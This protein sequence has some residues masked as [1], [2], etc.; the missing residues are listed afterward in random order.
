M[1]GP[2]VDRCD[3]DGMDVQFETCPLKSAWCDAGLAD[4]EVTQLCEIAAQADYGTLET[5]GF[6]V[7]IETWRPGRTGCCVPRIRRRVSTS[8]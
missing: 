2:R 5:A 7:A 1:F 8:S 3:A 4:D 6:A